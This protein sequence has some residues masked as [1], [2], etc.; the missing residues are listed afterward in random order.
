MLNAQ[1]IRLE[2]HQRVAELIRR[3]AA[4][5]TERWTARAR[6]E[7][8]QQTHLRHDLLLDHLPAFLE[9]LAE[10][11]EATDEDIA[12][13]HQLPAFQHGEQRW[14]NGWSLPEVIR[15]YQILRTVLIEFLDEA[16]KGHLRL[17]EVLAV[18]QALDEA[19]A[20][21]V[22]M[23]MAHR[24]MEV[25]QGERERVLKETHATEE[26]LQKKARNLEEIDRH[27]DEFLAVLGHELRNPLAPIR[28]VL[29]VLRL[30]EP[31]LKTLGWAQ[32]V[33][34]R[35]V[36]QM[37]RMV[38][39][40]LDVARLGRG[41]IQLRL[42]RLDMGRLLREAAEDRRTTIEE[43]GL[44]LAVDVPATGIWVRGD[45]VR[46]TQIVT[47]L[48]NNAAKFTPPRG[49]VTLALAR[50]EAAARA[51]VVVRD[52]GAG[53]AEA[54]LPHIFEPFQQ[55]ERSRYQSQ[56]GLGLGLALVKGLI[57]THGGGVSAR[58]AGPGQGAEFTFWLPLVPQPDA[59]SHDRSQP[60]SSSIS[61]GLTRQA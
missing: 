10:S 21:S 42:E 52:T 27:K 39:D 43:R 3:D 16:L 28:N 34:E 23:F 1:A 12:L 38:D 11:L 59:A 58:S 17:R 13:R 14:D 8:P 40:L 33:V 51:L 30:K 31:D 7:Q 55:A 53:I 36:Q 32:G 6:S 2:R 35:Q 26:R 29:Q 44:I 61:S 50:D 4:L 37:T 19:I 25:R 57:E 45:A 46:V 15:D 49:T 60:A 48:L 22:G 9:G 56:G 20:A 47:N 18:D 5:I 54:D 24:D 41:K